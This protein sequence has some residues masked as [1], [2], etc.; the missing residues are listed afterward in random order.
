MQALRHDA[1]IG[2]APNEADVPDVGLT[3]LFGLLDPAVGQELVDKLNVERE[4]R[5]TTYR[6]VRTNAAINSIR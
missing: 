4:L 6:G 5:N 3:L 2:M 1:D